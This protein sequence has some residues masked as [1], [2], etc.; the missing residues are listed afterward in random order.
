MLDGMLDGR[1]MQGLQVAAFCAIEMQCFRCACMC[2]GMITCRALPRWQ[3]H[4]PKSSEQVGL[5]A[6]LGPCLG[7]KRHLTEACIAVTFC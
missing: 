6:P 7:V 3:I 1:S 2:Q 4:S 5:G